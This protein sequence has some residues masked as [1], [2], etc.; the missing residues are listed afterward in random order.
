MGGMMSR[1]FAGCV[2]WRRPGWL[3]AQAAR[4]GL[5]TFWTSPRHCKSNRGG[6]SVCA[7]LIGAPARQT[8]SLPSPTRLNLHTDRS[9]TPM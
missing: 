8:A 9:V 7:Q 6:R 5:R 3:P 1:R 2:A 4:R